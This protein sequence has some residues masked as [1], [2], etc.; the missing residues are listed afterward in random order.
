MWAQT[1][2]NINNISNAGI[3]YQLLLIHQLSLA[4][5]L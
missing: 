1:I 3:I 5:A 4:N 2:K